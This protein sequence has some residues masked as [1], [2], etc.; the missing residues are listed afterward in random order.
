MA[1]A[2]KRSHHHCLVRSETSI[3]LQTPRSDIKRLVLIRSSSLT[4]MRGIRHE[5]PI[6][7]RRF[8]VLSIAVLF[9]SACATAVPNVVY[10]PVAGP[11]TSG[12]L[13][14]VLWRSLIHLDTSGAEGAKN[15]MDA[16]A[17]PSDLTADDN[18][19]LYSITPFESFGVKTILNGDVYRQYAPYQF[20]R[21]GD[22]G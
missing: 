10:S 19:R 20:H 2:S 15:E 5:H 11:D 12:S 4:G 16:K 18:S 14:F 22:P 21:C 17:V 13:K 7:V 6:P 3:G 8:L 9:L 1:G